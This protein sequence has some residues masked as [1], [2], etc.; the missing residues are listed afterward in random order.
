MRPSPSGRATRP[1]K[2][3]SGAVAFVRAYTAVS[4][5]RSSPE[6][7]SGAFGWWLGNHIIPSTS[8]IGMSP[9]CTAALNGG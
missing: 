3:A 8:S 9:R 2:C 4:A 5:S 6:A 7:P 1:V